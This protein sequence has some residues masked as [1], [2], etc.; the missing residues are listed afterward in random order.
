MNVSRLVA[1]V[2]GYFYSTSADVLAVHLYGGASATATVGGT[3]VRVRDTGNYPWSGAIRITLDPQAS[4][5]FTLKLRIPGWARNATASV[6][7]TP[8]KVAENLDKGYLAIARTWTKGDTIDLDLPMPVERL[9]AHPSVRMDAG[10]TALKRGPL[11]YCAEQVD[12]PTVP[13]ERVRLPRTATVAAR[14]RADLFDGVVTL[15]ADGKAA[16]DDGWTDTL[17]RSEPPQAAD[18]T[19]TAVP[20]YLWNNREPGRMLVWIPEA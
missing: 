11:V 7:G 14:Q 12:N 16:S 10:R 5:A 8:V 13:V 18:A 4:T 15:V 19:W 3:T 20:Y 2:G 9:Y 17:Y 1:S 6:N